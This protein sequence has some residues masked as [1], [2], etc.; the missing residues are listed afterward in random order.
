MEITL[1]H[2][3]ENGWVLIEG[4]TN[5]IS[6]LEERIYTPGTPANADFILMGTQSQTAVLG[7]KTEALYNILEKPNMFDDLIVI[8]AVND[9]IT[10]VFAID[11]INGPGQM[12][13]RITDAWS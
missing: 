5:T 12:A 10:E 11:K 2:K 4:D 1:K 7:K 13:R 6:Q 3:L 9:T 8:C